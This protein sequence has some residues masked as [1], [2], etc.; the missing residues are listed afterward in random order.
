MARQYLFSDGE[1][2]TRNRRSATSMSDVS[3][4]DEHRHRHVLHPIP[5]QS[6]AMP[7]QVPMTIAS[8]STTTTP[9]KGGTTLVSRIESV[10]KWGVRWRRGTSSTP[11]EVIVML[12]LL[13]LF[14]FSTHFL[15]YRS[16]QP[17]NHNH[18]TPNLHV[19]FCVRSFNV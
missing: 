1:G 3:S 8:G 17:P 14:F 10:K 19:I 4:V 7:S 13:L 2:P 18:R 5:P 12:F 15:T 9:T 11:S 16:V 6:S